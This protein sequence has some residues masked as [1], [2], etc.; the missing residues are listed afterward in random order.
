M[1]TAFSPDRLSGIFDPFVSTKATGLGMG[2]SICRRII[3]NHGGQIEAR[4]HEDGGGA[5]Q[6][7]APGSISGSR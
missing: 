4:N 7:L 3:E 6:F 1:D 2:L 5:L